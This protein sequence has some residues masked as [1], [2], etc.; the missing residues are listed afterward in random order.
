MDQGTRGVQHSQEGATEVFDVHE[1]PPR[2][3]VALNRD[4]T[5]GVGRGHEVVDHDVG[6]QARRHAVGRRVAQKR[7]AE[8]LVGQGGD[9]VLHQHLG[10]A[11]RRD[12]V[13]GGLFVQHRFPGYPVQAA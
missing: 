4:L 1:R 6:A 2:R 11:V 9:I 10:P 7:R 12:R 3:A 8:V 13:E 5:G